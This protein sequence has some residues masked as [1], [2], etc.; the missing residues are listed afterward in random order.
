M[1]ELPEVEITL[2]GIRPHL[3]QQCVSNVI[4]RN[5]NLRWPIP[6]ALPKLLH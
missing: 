6:P 2:R 3:Q 4:I 5:A 1:P